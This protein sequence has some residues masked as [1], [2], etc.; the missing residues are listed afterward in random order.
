MPTLKNLSYGSLTFTLADGTTRTLGPRET[1][2]VSGEDADNPVFQQYLRDRRIAVIPSA[3][4]GRDQS[5]E[6]PA[7]RSSSSSTSSSSSSPAAPEARAN[8]KPT[9]VAE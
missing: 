9:P 5:D 4:G 6:T 8:N 7:E 3:G 1:A 2:E